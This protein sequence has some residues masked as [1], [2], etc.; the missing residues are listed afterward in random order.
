[1][2]LADGYRSRADTFARTARTLSGMTQEQE[3]LTRAAEAYRQ[4]ADLYSKVLGFADVPR[5][6]RAVQ[7]GLKQ[8]EQRLLELSRGPAELHPP[9]NQRAFIVR[10]SIRIPLSANRGASWA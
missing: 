9:Q 8:V 2:Q 4:A 1:V 3:Y 10:A 5:S 6:M 7:L